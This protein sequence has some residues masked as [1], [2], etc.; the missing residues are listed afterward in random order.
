MGIIKNRLRDAM[1]VYRRNHDLLRFIKEVGD[2]A[3][4]H[5]HYQWQRSHFDDKLDEA[6]KELLG[7]GNPSDRRG[8]IEVEEDKLF[9]PCQ[10]LFAVEDM[11]K[12]NMIF[13]GILMKDKS[14]KVWLVAL[15]PYHQQADNLMKILRTAGNSQLQRLTFVAEERDDMKHVVFS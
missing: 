5:I 4:S 14:G 7:N 11:R 2:I 3:D 8:S 12:K 13:Y 15:C 6:Y 9:E 1:I 10:Y